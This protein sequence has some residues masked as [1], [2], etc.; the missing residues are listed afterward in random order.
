MFDRTL[1][2]SLKCQVNQFGLNRSYRLTRNCKNSKTH[3]RNRTERW[4]G[5]AVRLEVASANYWGCAGNPSTGNT[6]AC[7]SEKRCTMA[8]SIRQKRIEV[9]VP[10]GSQK[11]SSRNSK[12]FKLG[13]RERTRMDG[14]F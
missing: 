4:C 3:C 2:G 9:A 13:T 10:S 5:S 12:S 6:S 14:F 1:Y 8:K 7:G 11:P